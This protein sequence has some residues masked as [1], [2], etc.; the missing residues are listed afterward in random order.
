MLDLICAVQSRSL[1][2]CGSGA[3]IHQGPGGRVNRLAPSHRRLVRA[4]LD[5]LVDLD[6]PRRVPSRR[7]G[8]ARGAHR[9]TGSTAA[10]TAAGAWR[11]H[12][13]VKLRPR[14]YRRRRL[15]RLGRS[16]A[17]RRRRHHA[18]PTV[19]PPGRRGTRQPKAPDRARRRG[20]A[21][22][23]WAPSCRRAQ[24]LARRRQEVAAARTRAHHPGVGRTHT[25]AAVGCAAAARAR[26]SADPAST[27]RR[28]P[29]CVG[30]ACSRRSAFSGG[31]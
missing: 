29:R 16:L 9:S 26:A 15:G 31:R 10:A 23:Q 19:R 24:V 21:G 22:G 27:H 30:A 6:M 14:R 28:C 25:S 18:Q 8:S 4:A 1:R 12:S 5:D 3:Q 13:L 7:C 17:A 11:F 2:S 20:A